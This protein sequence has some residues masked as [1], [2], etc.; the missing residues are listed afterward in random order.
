AEGAVARG[1]GRGVDALLPPPAGE[2]PRGVGA[3]AERGGRGS[4]YRRRLAADRLRRE[5]CPAAA[6]ELLARR[7][8]EAAA[9]TGGGELRPARRAVATVRAID[10]PAGGAAH[11]SR[12]GIGI[13]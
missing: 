2:A 12:H 5:G 10:V 9:W 3:A 6:A 7:G 4:R 13:P 1:V 11:L 8:L